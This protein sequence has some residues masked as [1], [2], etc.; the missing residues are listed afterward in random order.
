MIETART[1]QPGGVQHE[2]AGQVLKLRAREVRDMDTDPLRAFALLVAC[3]LL[4]PVSATQI[5]SSR[6]STRQFDGAVRPLVYSTMLIPIPG[7][8]A[9]ARKLRGSAHDA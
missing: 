4:A 9:V 1:Q 2:A 6:R 7:F 5:A 8:A 3:M